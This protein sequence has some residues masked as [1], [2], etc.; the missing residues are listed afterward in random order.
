MDPSRKQC[1]CQFCPECQKRIRAN[2]PAWLQQQP[3]LKELEEQKRKS[4]EA[5]EAGFAGAALLTTKASASADR[6][7]ASALGF[8]PGGS[9]SSSSTDSSPKTDTS[10]MGF[11]QDIPKDPPSKDKHAS[12]SKSD[13]REEPGPSGATGS[14]GPKPVRDCIPSAAELAAVR[15]G[16][17]CR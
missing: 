12:S 15:N 13:G 11:G 1:N 6:M 14:G 8:R 9:D 7:V 17:A 3:G 2:L 4:E 5:G 16:L 10:D